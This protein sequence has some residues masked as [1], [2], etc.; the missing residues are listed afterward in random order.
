MKTKEMIDLLESFN[1][2]LDHCNLKSN[3]HIFHI[4]AIQFASNL[5][6][7]LLEAISSF[8]SNFR[9]LFTDDNKWIFFEEIF[10]DIKKFTFGFEQKIIKLI[11][12][13]LVCLSISDEYVVLNM[14]FSKLNPLD[15]EFG[16]YPLSTD[17]FLLFEYVYC[18]TIMHISKKD[19][20]DQKFIFEHCL[21]VANF[22][23]QESNPIVSNDCFE[24]H[25]FRETLRRLEKLEF[26]FNSDSFLVHCIENARLSQCYWLELHLSLFLSDQDDGHKNRLNDRMYELCK[27]LEVL[28]RSVFICM[29]EKR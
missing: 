2:T 8:E 17:Q 23:R 3:S 11:I 26:R 10:E 21:K 7:I 22:L 29:N 9:R 14:F 12:E 1:S 16:K 18:K 20:R 6:I 24:E 27:L 28:D 13:I 15:S 25:F 19:E 5:V 4:E